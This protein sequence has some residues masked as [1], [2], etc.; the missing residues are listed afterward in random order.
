MEMWKSWRSPRVKD[1]K[2]QIERDREPGA[3]RFNLLYGRRLAFADHANFNLIFA[4]KLVPTEVSGHGD[5]ELEGA[6]SGG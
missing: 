6:G 5:G 4:G 3:G 2:V 1:N